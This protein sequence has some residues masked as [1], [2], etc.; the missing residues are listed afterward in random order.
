M[1]IALFPSA[2]HPHFGGVEELVRQ[3]AHELR[4]RG[5]HAIVLTNRWP[6][7]LPAQ[8]THEGIPVYRIPFRVP[9]RCA[10]AKL[11]YCLTGWQMR[12]RMLRALRENRIELLHVQCV[13]SNAHYAMIAKARLGLPLVVTLQGELTMDAGQIFQRSDLARE[14]LRRS[15]EVA[16][17]VTGC[18]GQTLADAE[19]FFGR[20]IPRPSRAIFNGAS[21]DDFA[22]AQPFAHGRPYVFA[23]GRM[24]PQKGFDVLLRAHAQSGVTSHDL[25]IAGDGPERPALERLAGAL[26][27]AE[28]VRFLG[29]KDRGEVPSLFKGADL[30]VLPSRAHEGLP[31][32]CAEAMAAG[33]AVVAT[34]SGGAP[35]AVLH[36]QTGLI[37]DRED[38]DGLARSIAELCQDSGLRERFARAGQERAGL[39]SWPV[40]T[41]EYE[42]LYRE[43]AGRGAAPGRAVTAAA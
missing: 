20:P 13:S 30:F 34:R 32:V 11:S 19:A 24:V 16:D 14:T 25:L 40:I 43:L 35:E 28:R 12:L 26:G 4:R 21:V 1:N 41:D 23:I 10:K 9:E 22:N 42:A 18:S 27:L 7:S 3:L 29:R 33:K 37:V 2:F 8:E 6:R 17:V 5:H 39:F 36:R 31:V 38:V 15:L